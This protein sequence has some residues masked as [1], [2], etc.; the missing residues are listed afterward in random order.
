MNKEQLDLAIQLASRN[1]NIVISHDSLSDGKK[2][3]MARNPELQGCK[4]QGMSQMEA[5][6]NLRDARIDYIYYLLEDGI[7]VPVPNTQNS[8]TGSQVVTPETLVYAAHPS[9]EDVIDA[10]IR[11]EGREDELETWSTSEAV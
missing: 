11:P 6:K 9:I 2:I 1:Y 10:V 5:I 7:D 4:A 8:I 3:Y